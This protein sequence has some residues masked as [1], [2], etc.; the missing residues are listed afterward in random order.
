[1]IGKI[2]Y[3]LA[4]FNVSNGLLKIPA[5]NIVKLFFLIIYQAVKNESF[6]AVLLYRLANYFYNRKLKVLAKYFSY[7]LKRRYACTISY[8][9]QI[10]AGLRFPH[11]YGIIIGGN[12]KVGKMT[13]IGQF[14]T[15]G[16]NFGLK[17]QLGKSVPTIGDWS[18]IC[19]GSVIAGPITV[20]DDV[21]IGANSVVT[22]D[23]PDHVIAGGNPGKIIKN[24]EKAATGNSNKIL[25][26]RYYGYP[27]DFIKNL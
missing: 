25:N 19:A 26:V 22:K 10:D 16:G 2:R 24:K 20:G 11:P 17:N 21:I 9:A 7:R 23:I 1:M 12:V 8:S 14:V 3:D 6:H 27:L 5:C 18:F 15:L 4:W 13:T